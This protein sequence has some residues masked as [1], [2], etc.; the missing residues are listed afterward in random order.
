MPLDASSSFSLPPALSSVMRSPLPVLA[1]ALLL[2]GCELQHADTPAAAT[3][4]AATDS[5]AAEDSL[6]RSRAEIGPAPEP[7]DLRFPT[8][9]DALFRDP[10]AF[11][12]PLDR[13]QIPGL[14]E[15]AWEGGQYGY[16][17]NPARGSRGLI[18]ARPP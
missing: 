11:F 7:L 13:A 18:F 2:V 8:G 4:L 6:A 1:A 5:A 17:R 14:R 12:S 15:H 9:N 10:A 3:T 16:V